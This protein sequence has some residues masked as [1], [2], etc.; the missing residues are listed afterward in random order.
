MRPSFTLPR[1]S[2]LLFEVLVVILISAVVGSQDVRA[3]RSA[4]Q[5]DTQHHVEGTGR[6]TAGG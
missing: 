4:S 2:Q 1:T 5:S 3:A 6:L